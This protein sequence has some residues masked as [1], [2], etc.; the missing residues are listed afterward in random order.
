MA[1]KKNSKWTKEEDTAL[2]QLVAKHGASGWK[3]VGRFK[4]CHF[5]FDM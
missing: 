3:N 2:K 5:L 4:F 1:K